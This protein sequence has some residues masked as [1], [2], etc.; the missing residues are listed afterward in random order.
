V[1]YPEQLIIP[2]R[3]DLTQYGVQETRT[4][5]QVAQLLKPGSGTV[6]MIVNS[7]CAALQG[8]PGRRLDLRSSITPVPIRRPRSLRVRI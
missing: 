6:L 3:R 2:M 5:E 4:P 8:R 7:V 1:R